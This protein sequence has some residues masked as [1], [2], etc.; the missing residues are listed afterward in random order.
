MGPCGGIAHRHDV[1]MPRKHQVRAGVSEPGIEVLDIGCVFICR[2]DPRY[3]K[4]KRFQHRLKCRERTAL[5]RGDRGAAD[6][7]LQIGDGIG[8]GHGQLVFV[9]RGEMTKRASPGNLRSKV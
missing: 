7:R 9:E 4:A 3:G 1:R 2:H 5:G 8:N 6:E